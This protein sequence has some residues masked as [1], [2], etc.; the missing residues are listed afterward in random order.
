MLWNSFASREDD[1]NSDDSDSSDH[2]RY[3][4]HRSKR[5][6]RDARAGA[7]WFPSFFDAHPAKRANLSPRRKSRRRDKNVAAILKQRSSRRWGLVGPHSSS[8]SIVV[9]TRLYPHLIFFSLS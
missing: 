7:S 5:E 6:P 2:A 3:R 1:A 8:I 4:A 9:F